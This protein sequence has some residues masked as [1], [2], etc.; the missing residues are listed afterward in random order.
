MDRERI[1]PN[2]QANQNPFS[3]RT[4][5]MNAQTTKKAEIGPILEKSSLG[6]Y[7]S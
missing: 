5:C 3:P 7:C 1:K 4:Y 6:G 2:S